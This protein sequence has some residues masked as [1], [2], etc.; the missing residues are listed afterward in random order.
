LLSW[1]IWFEQYDFEVEWIP[2]NTNWLAGAMTREMEKNDK[3]QVTQ[4]KN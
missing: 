2:R 3:N 1:Q 4:S